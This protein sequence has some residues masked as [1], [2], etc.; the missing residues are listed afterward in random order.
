MH[1]YCPSRVPLKHELFKDLDINRKHSTRYHSWL[2]CYERFAHC[3][4]NWAPG[5]PRRLWLH[6]E[7]QE[8][9]SCPYSLRRHTTRVGDG[10]LYTKFTCQIFT[11]TAKTSKLL[12][13]GHRVR[14]E[15]RQ[16]DEK[17][18]SHF[19]AVDECSKVPTANVSNTIG[20]LPSLYRGSNCML[21]NKQ[22]V[23]AIVVKL[24]FLENS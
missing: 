14:P 1:Y 5:C 19:A 8:S 12:A 16:G 11:Y 10:Q 3:F 22:P 13:L 6:L 17:R 21:T 4:F 24:D 20:S 2:V 23:V 9:L 15:I 7:T 18:E